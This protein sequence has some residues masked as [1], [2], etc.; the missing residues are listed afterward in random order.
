[1]IS[2]YLLLDCIML[3]ANLQFTSFHSLLCLYCKLM[4]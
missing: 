4:C 2:V 3:I 1:M